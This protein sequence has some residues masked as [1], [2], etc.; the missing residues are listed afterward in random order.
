MTNQEKEKLLAKLR[1]PIHIG[2]ISQYLLKLPMD[3]TQQEIDKLIS[4]GLIE[5]SK[6]A[7]E[8]YVIK[9]QYENLN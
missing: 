7:K 3:E 5:E 8:Y 6:Y 1:Q 4:E 2:Y 9:N